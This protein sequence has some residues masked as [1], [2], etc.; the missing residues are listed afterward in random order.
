VAPDDLRAF[1]H[2]NLEE[3][4]E[5]LRS[6]FRGISIL[7][8]IVGAGTLAAG[9]IGVSNIMLIIVRE[10]TKEIGIRRAVGAHPW[11]V[12]TQVVVET[13]ILTASA[14]Y[15]GMVAGIALVEVVNRTLPSGDGS[16]MF[17]NPQVGIAE[18]LRALSILMAAGVLAGLA[19]AQR[20]VQVS[21]IEAL[22]SE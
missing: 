2:F 6:L 5:K 3:E 19:P 14:G 12:V 4:Y 7:V 18:A 20:A 16:R 1:G 22:R 13:V 17:T 11:M 21:P 15:F 8:W 9:A 10:R